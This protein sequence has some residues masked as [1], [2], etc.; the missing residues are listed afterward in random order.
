MHPLFIIKKTETFNELRLK[1]FSFYK[2]KQLVLYIIRE[3]FESFQQSPGGTSDDKK[4]EKIL[5]Y[6]NWG[7]SQFVF[8]G[9]DTIIFMENLKTE[10]YK[11]IQK[12]S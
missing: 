6:K 3:H 1:N 12:Y 2:M 9:N 11:T 10:N 5:R 8:I 4:L 7:T